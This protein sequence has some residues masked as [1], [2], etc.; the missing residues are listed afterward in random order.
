MTLQL[1]AFSLP[2]RNAKQQLKHFN[3][4]QI[5]DLVIILTKG[6]VNKIKTATIKPR[7]CSRCSKA[8]HMIRTCIESA[9]TNQ[10]STSANSDLMSARI[11]VTDEFNNSHLPTS[12][13]QQVSS[14]SSQS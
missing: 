9:I 14:Q 5:H 2:F 6:L 11:L 12:Y 3:L 10:F 4:D 13:S 1:Q 7:K 8:G